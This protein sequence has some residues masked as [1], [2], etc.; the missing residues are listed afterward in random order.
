MENKA[1]PSFTNLDHLYEKYERLWVCG[2]GAEIH[3]LLNE[4]WRLVGTVSATVTLSGTVAYDYVLGRTKTDI[5]DALAKRE[6]ELVEKLKEVQQKEQELDRQ[7]V[8]L[9]EDIK[10]TRTA[11]N[12]IWKN[13]S[14]MANAKLR[15]D[16]QMGV[17]VLLR[18]FHDK[19]S[20]KD[21]NPYG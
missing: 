3:R 8:G 9:D 21:Y 13:L 10:R 14:N 5:E 6:Q 11:L 17:S 1:L 18:Y 12:N 15:S 4:G 2:T 19:L 16:L 7:K 20:T